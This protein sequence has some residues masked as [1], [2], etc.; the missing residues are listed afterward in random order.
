[1]PKLE[2]NFKFY[3]VISILF[4][5]YRHEFGNKGQIYTF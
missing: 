5:F 2:T 1:M 4:E 3:S